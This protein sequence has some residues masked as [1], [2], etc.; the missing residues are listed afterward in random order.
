MAELADGFLALPGGFGTIEELSE[1]SP[2]DN[3]VCTTN[4]WVC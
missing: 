3:W 4:R 2:G 1:F